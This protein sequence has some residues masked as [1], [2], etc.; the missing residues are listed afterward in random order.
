MPHCASV[1][2]GTLPHQLLPCGNLPPPPLPVH[3]PWSSSSRCP[4]PYRRAVQ[5]HVCAIRVQAEESFCSTRWWGFG[6]LCSRWFQSLRRAQDS[7]ILCCRASAS[8]HHSGSAPFRQPSSPSLF[9]APLFCDLPRCGTGASQL[10][11]RTSPPPVAPSA[12]PL[13]FSA[14]PVLLP[15]FLFLLP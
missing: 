6:G 3:R 1:L 14:P 15:R 8:L 10:P 12:P 11:C 2:P 7:N 9:H 4:G 13:A 5:G